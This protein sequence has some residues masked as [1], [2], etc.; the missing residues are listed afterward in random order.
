M[1]GSRDTHVLIEADTEPI[2]ATRRT[3]YWPIRGAHLSPPHKRTHCRLPLK[4]P[5][6]R[7]HP[8]TAVVPTDGS[9]SSINWRITETIA[10]LRDT[11]APAYSVIFSFS[12]ESLE[13][14]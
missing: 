5:N 12:R 13:N 3:A 4:V 1:G 6:S 2:G 11:E 7:M 14:A 8:R 10:R 9:T